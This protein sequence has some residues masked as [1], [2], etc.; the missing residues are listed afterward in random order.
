MRI[1]RSFVLGTLVCVLVGLSV[2]A[3][4]AQAAPTLPNSMSAV[5]DS[6][7]R[8]YNTCSSSF[9]DCP[10]NSWSTGTSAT[11]NSHYSRVLASNPSIS[12]RSFNDAKSGAKMADLNGQV[13]TVNSRGV[14]YVTIL[15]GGNDVCTSSAS[16]MTTVATFSAQ[17]RTAMTTLTGGSSNTRILVSSVPDVYNLWATLKNNG[18]A[19]FAWALFRICQSMLANPLSTAQADVDRRALVRQRNIDFNT[20]LATVCAAFANC[21][22][23]GNAVFNTKFTST[24][25]S[26][27]DYF[28]PSISGQRRLA[29]VTWGAGYWAPLIKETC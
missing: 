21:L 1:L 19:R 3:G 29:C 5:G 14:D 2:T 23:D 24:D 25:V 28:H 10:P 17:F 26:T 8:A 16:T 15:M 12:G 18:S 27:R 20:E 4:V 13:T 6:I 7:T 22:F 11:V 9:V